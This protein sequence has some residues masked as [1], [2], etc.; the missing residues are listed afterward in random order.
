MMGVFSINGSVAAA[1]M[2]VCEDFTEERAQDGETGADD[3]DG[4]FDGGP[5]GG[6]EDGVGYVIE[7]DFGEGG[8]ADDRGDADAGTESC[9]QRRA[10]SSAR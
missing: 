3:A 10:W 6:G 4:L 5:H 2:A 7:V 8:D 9:G 1:A